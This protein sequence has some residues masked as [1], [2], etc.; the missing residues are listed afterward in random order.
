MK[1]K[2]LYRTYVETPHG[3]MIAMAT[4]K[5]LC[6]LEFAKPDRS[7]LLMKRLEKWY[8]GYETLDESC[9]FI[10]AAKKW[11]ADYFLGNFDALMLPTLDMR[12]TAFERRVWDALLQIPLGETST[13]GTLAAKL[14]VPGG[15]R[16]VGGANHRNPVSI[17]VPCHRVIGHNDALVGYGGGLDLKKTLLAHEAQ[18][19]GPRRERGAWTL[20]S[21]NPFEKP[22]GI[23]TSPKTFVNSL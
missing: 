16:A 5:G 4:E 12:G 9:P 17:I 15:A 11:L 13:Y 10:E 23:P 6:A 14:N 2:A 8:P 18:H 3:P 1:K 19:T 20:S 7:K 22:R 21:K